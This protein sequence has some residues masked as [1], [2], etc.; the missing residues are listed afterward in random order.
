MVDDEIYRCSDDLSVPTLLKD[1]D[2]NPIGLAHRTSYLMNSLLSHKSRRYGFWTLKRFQIEIGLSRF[3]CFTERNADAFTEASGNDPRQ[4]DFD[5]WLGT[6][7]IG[8]WIASQRHN[9]LANYLYL[10]GHVVTADWDEA[11]VDLYPDKNVLVEDGS[12]SN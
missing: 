5:I 9:H 12:Y 1:D 2:G 10:D 11:V 4:D 6:D 3:I 8:D 7:I